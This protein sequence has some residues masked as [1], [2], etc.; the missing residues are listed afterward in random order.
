M[1]HVGSSGLVCVCVWCVG[2]GVGVGEWDYLRCKVLGAP[3]LW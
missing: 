2:V 3:C 1:L